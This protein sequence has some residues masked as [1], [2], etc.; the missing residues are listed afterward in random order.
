MSSRQNSEPIGPSL[1]NIEAEQALL[2]AILCRNDAL[3]LIA[4]DLKPDDFSEPI[5]ARIY[6][7]AITLLADGRSASP[8][9]LASHFADDAT[10]KEIGGNTYLARLAGS[11]ATILNVPEYARIVRD[12]SARRRAIARCQEAVADL[13]SLPID[14]SA[15][16]ACSGLLA[17]LTAIAEGAGNSKRALSARGVIAAAIDDAALAYQ[18]EGRRPDATATGIG[19]LDAKIG[20]LVRS[21]LVIIG[22]R[23]SMGKTAL[24]LQLLYNSARAG[25][26]GLFI[27][28]EMNAAQIGHRLLAMRTSIEYRRIAWGKFSERDWTHIVEAGRVIEGMPFA[29]EDRSSMTI[30]QLG[31]AVSR[32][33]AKNRKLGLVV[34]DYL[35]LV[36]PGDRYRGRKVDELAEISAGCKRIAKQYEVCFVALQQLSRNLEQRDNKRPTLADLR[37]SGSIEQDADC[38]LF[39]YRDA[40][41]IGRDL[42]AATAGSKEHAELD[43]RLSK[44]NS[45]MEIIVAKN[46]QGAVGTA[47]VYCDVARNIITDLDTQRSFDGEPL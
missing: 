40:Y 42:E 8:V 10:L 43:E 21:D 31:A 47:R 37:D 25:L 41:Y 3:S 4:C 13:A 32:A 7:A 39:P 1:T 29:V 33:K 14:L 20:G 38:V 15:E 12:L 36:V 46:R 11:A 18:N 26:P 17:D 45:V 35:A 23:P 6:E 19:A 30:S 24:A 2:G 28:L 9:T 5:H 27:S 22:G 44:A 34:L 16:E